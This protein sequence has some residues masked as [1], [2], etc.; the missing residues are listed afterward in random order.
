MEF[1]WP[2]EVIGE[3]YTVSGKNILT[4]PPQNRD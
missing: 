2:N 4:L 1:L 3:K